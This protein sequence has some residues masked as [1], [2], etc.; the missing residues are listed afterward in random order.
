MA[1][2]TQRPVSQRFRHSKCSPRAKVRFTFVETKRM[3]S[4]TI[5]GLGRRAKMG[6]TASASRV[7][8]PAEP[9]SQA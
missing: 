4:Y 7:V 2:I 6:R 3:R 5:T 8:D 1:A 9:I